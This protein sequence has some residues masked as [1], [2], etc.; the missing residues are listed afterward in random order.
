MQLI[1]GQLVGQLAAITLL[2]NAVAD[3]GCTTQVIVGSSPVVAVP[4]KIGHR[5]QQTH[6]FLV[7]G[8]GTDG[9]NHIAEIL[10]HT[11]VEVQLH[12]RRYQIEDNL[13]VVSLLI[14]FHFIQPEAG[15]IGD[16]QTGKGSDQTTITAHTQI[17]DIIID[18]LSA[19]PH[20]CLQFGKF[21]GMRTEILQFIDQFTNQ[22]KRF[23]GPIHLS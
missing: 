12:H 15:R 23:I 6:I 19:L 13:R 16:T 17:I 1:D 11:V 8:V 4:F 18:G 9:L 7:Q 10:H 2:L 3:V 14:F 20:A 21:F 22:W 5:L